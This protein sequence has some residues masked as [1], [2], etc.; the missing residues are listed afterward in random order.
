MQFTNFKTNILGTLSFDLQMPKWRKPQNF[1]VYPMHEK[2]EAILIQSDKRWA[3]IDVNTGEMY[4]TNGKGGHP[5][6]WLLILQKAKGEAERHQ[7]DGATL[8]C[9]KMQIFTTAGKSVGNSVMTTDNSG[10]YS[11]I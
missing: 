5:N 6:S 9:V 11:I 3:E 2:S 8:S 7:V 4:M 1:C 10:A